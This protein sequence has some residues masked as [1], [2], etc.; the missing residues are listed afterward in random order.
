MDIET[1]AKNLIRIINDRT[2]GGTGYVLGVLIASMPMSPVP[3]DQ[4][5]REYPRLLY[6]RRGDTDETLVVQSC[7]EETAAVA[8]GWSRTPS[9]A[10]LNFPKNMVE[11]NFARGR[12][13]RR[14]L[15]RNPEE[16]KIL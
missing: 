7:E 14:C 8:E 2:R 12:D 16:L 4:S 1:F 6:K 9:Q 11:V 5:Q 15:L 3:G 10:P 13:F